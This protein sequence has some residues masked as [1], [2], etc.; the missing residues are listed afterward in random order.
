MNLRS[1]TTGYATRLVTPKYPAAAK[2]QRVEDQ[3]TVKLLINVQTGIVE[4]ACLA[5]GDTIFEQT[6]KDAALRSTFSFAG[7]KALPKQYHYAEGTM[8]YNFVPE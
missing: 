7:I 1:S 8:I 5:K 6:S 2:Q 4:Q 3:V